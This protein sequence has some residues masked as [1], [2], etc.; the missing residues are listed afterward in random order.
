MAVT[1]PA[2]QEAGFFWCSP[3][4]FNLIVEA[5]AP[6][7]NKYFNCLDCV[8]MVPSQILPVIPECFYRGSMISIVKD[9][10]PAQNNC[11][12]DKLREHHT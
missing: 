8:Y 4:F 2:S 3:L 1:C 12:N 6:D 10:I 5:I 9:W 11:R 7:D